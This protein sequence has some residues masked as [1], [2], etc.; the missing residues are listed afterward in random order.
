MQTESPSILNGASVAVTPGP[1]ARA[2]GKA[3]RTA[4]APSPGSPPVLSPSILGPAETLEQGDAVDAFVLPPAAAAPATAQ[5]S[6]AAAVRRQKKRANGALSIGRG[7]STAVP[8]PEGPSVPSG[9]LLNSDAGLSTTEEYGTDEKQ[10]NEFLKLH[11]MLSLES[12]SART[13][14]L[15]Q[16]LFE[17]ATIA[18]PSLPLVPKSYDDSM[19]R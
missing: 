1:S 19:L 18:A 4:Q 5:S 12:T 13:L 8:V 9:E 2:A 3:R 11:P 16:G 17:R 10:L 14:Q 6:S 7:A 15:V